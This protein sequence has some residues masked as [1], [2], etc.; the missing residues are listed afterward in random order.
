MVTVS[1]IKGVIVLYLLVS[2]RPPFFQARDTYT[3]LV[4]T[5][6][7]VTTAVAEMTFVEVL[8]EVT[9]GTAP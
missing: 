2:L 3:V 6:L 1:V 9:T 5:A 7:V 4:D 8:V